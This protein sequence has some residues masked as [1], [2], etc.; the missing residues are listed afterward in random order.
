MESSA[1][2]DTGARR[3]DFRILGPVEVH[4]LGTGARIVPSG[5]KQ[6]ALLAALV[7]RAA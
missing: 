7:V 2:D 6:R 1:R 5:A 3:L 4:D